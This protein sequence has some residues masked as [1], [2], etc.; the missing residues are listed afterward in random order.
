MPLGCCLFICLL[1]RDKAPQPLCSCV[2][3]GLTQRHYSDEAFPQAGLT[4]R[5]APGNKTQT[6]ESLGGWEEK[7]MRPLAFSGKGSSDVVPSK[8]QTEALGQLHLLSGTHC[9]STGRSGYPEAQN[10]AELS[11]PP[12][13]GSGRAI[14]YSQDMHEAYALFS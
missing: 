2:S 11:P 10:V 1:P 9:P 13:V 14:V 12:N 7:P 8:R 5:R 6:E 3:L 4:A